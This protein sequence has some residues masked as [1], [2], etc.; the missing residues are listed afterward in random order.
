MNVSIGVI[1]ALYLL[2][3]TCLVLLSDKASVYV[4]L[5]DKKT[6]LSGAFIGGVMLSAV[7]SL[8]ELFTSIS[9]ALL[10]DK[11]GLAMGNILGSNLFNLVI[12][13]ILVPLFLTTFTKVNIAKSHFMVGLFTWL[14]FGALAL[15]YTGILDLSLASISLTSVVIIVLYVCGIRCLSQEESSFEDGDDQ[16]PL[17][18]QQVLLRFVVVA[19]GIVTLSICITYLTDD[20]ATTFNLGNGLAGALFLG[21]A[22]SLPELASSIVLFRMGNYNIAIGNIIGSCIFNFMIL[23][24]TDVLYLGHGIYDFS[25]PKTINLLF[26]GAIATPLFLLM[27]RYN[28]KSVCIATSVGIIAC[29]LAFLVV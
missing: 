16:N 22:T 25:D 23:G 14:I 4:D 29:Y 5:L 21:I 11:P 3:A 27:T 7:T 19:V 24:F 6:T 15:N 26:F 18:V 13:S 28:K 10:L 12:L 8:P 9:S 17:T 2:V 1:I 20:I